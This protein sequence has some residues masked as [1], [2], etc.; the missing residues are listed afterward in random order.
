MHAA[1]NI[2]ITPTDLADGVV[3]WAAM[4]GHGLDPAAARLLSDSN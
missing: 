3:C 1:S 4:P 2:F